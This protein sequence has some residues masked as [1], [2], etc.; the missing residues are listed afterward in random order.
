[1]HRS[2]AGVELDIAK[3]TNTRELLGNTLHTEQVFVFH[4]QATLWSYDHCLSGLGRQWSRR[5]SLH[6]SLVVLLGDFLVGYPD[7]TVHHF[8]IGFLLDHLVSGID[9][10]NTL[11]NRILKH[12]VVQFTL[13][14]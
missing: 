10:L 4:S 11:A 6:E 1:M 13:V 14:H 3:S 9:S 2:L 5:D 12:G 7:D 8:R